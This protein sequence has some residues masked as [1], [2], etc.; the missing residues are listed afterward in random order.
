[1]RI[2]IL[3]K[4]NPCNLNPKMNYR[5]LSKAVYKFDWDG[6]V[7]HYA[8]RPKNQKEVDDIFATQGKIYKTIRL[9]VLLD[10]EPEPEPKPVKKK[11]G[12]PKKV[13]EP[14]VV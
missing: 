6:D 10:P 2:A 5:G 11:P 14:V 4:K 9:T 13:K 1:M 8:Y 7:Q 3:G 12:R